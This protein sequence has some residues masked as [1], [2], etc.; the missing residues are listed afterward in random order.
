MAAFPRACA[1]PYPVVAGGLPDELFHL[2]V[3]NP[4]FVPD[5]KDVDRLELKVGVCK[6]L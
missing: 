5:A 1:I 6:A 4:D 2:L 3:P